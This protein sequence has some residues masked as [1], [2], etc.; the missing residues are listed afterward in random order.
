MAQLHRRVLGLSD[1]GQL[2][3]PGRS[4]QGAAH[5]ARRVALLASVLLALGVTARGAAQ[6]APVDVDGAAE[7][8][9]LA[10]PP[11]SA[12]VQM[13][14]EL[15]RERTRP[16]GDLG[17]DLGSRDSAIRVRAYDALRSLSASRV[18][19]V[20]AR[21]RELRLSND[22]PAAAAFNT[23]A[24]V[25][26]HMGFERA[27][28]PTDVALGVRQLLGAQRMPSSTLLQ[29]AER[30]ALVR[31]L[32][33]MDS[34]AADRVMIG[35]FQRGWSVWQWEARHVV[36]RRG[37]RMLPA[38]IEGRS[39]G[40]PEVRRWAVGSIRRLGV[41]SVGAAVQMVPP[42][43]L[44]DVLRAYASLSDLNAMPAVITFV[45]HPDD[46]VREASRAATAS[47]ERNAIWQ[48]RLAY[49][50]KLGENAD[51]SWSWQTT[52]QRLYDGLDARRL[53]PANELLDQGLVAAQAGDW[54][55]MRER[56]D[57]AL[58]REPLLPRRSEMG[59]GY[60]AEATQRLEQLTEGA[61]AAGVD[62]ALTLLRRAIRLSPEHADANAWRATVAFHEAERARE[63]G[64]LDEGAYEAVLAVR[65]DHAG[66]SAVLADIEDG[67]VGE[68]EPAGTLLAAKLLALLGVLL[69]LPYARLRPWAMRA[70]DGVNAAVARVR[71][72]RAREAFLVGATEHVRVPEVVAD[73]PAS[74][75][76]VVGPVFAEPATA[77]AVASS[78][79]E[80]PAPVGVPAYLVEPAH[81]DAAVPM[82][83][84]AYPVEPAHLDA[85]PLV[86]VAAPVVEP[87]RVA[88]RVET[89]APMGLLAAAPVGVPASLSDA[90]APVGALP[91]AAPMGVL[92]LATRP[93]WLTRVGEGLEPLYRT[94]RQLAFFARSLARRLLPA[95]AKAA[96]P[97]P[98]APS[99]ARVHAERL[100]ARASE[101]AP[102]LAQVVAHARH[103][104]EMVAALKPKK[105]LPSMAEMRKT[106]AMLASAEPPQVAQP[107]V[108][109]PAIVDPYVLLTTS[110]VACADEVDPESD[111]S[112][113]D[114][115][116]FGDSEPG[117]DT[118][119]DE[120]SEAP[121]QLPVSHDLLT[122]L[123]Q[124]AHDTSPG[125]I[126]APDT[127]PG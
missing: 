61:D 79:A 66:A 43:Q 124:F 126:E 73:A 77:V 22:P 14:P 36:A 102:A 47:Y 71:E 76:H 103:P 98:V 19:D 104:R 53:A 31:G 40:N 121:T 69:L 4:Q 100:L 90:P 118:A 10:P 41:D 5:L 119:D 17:A 94:A 115:L 84:P 87:A 2:A 82:G 29:V 18:T 44:P 57:R 51:L 96:A 1:R 81:L 60:A 26:H 75:P 111:E 64:V 68:V 11:P 70:R 92:P 28:D 34:L 117:L 62:G 32:E 35:F 45:D 58:R 39:A 12:P 67:G 108:V 21:L 93:T 54:E 114:E 16:L 72:R 97:A 78:L 52:M 24:D 30:M 85:T 46:A 101:R 125:L 8:L 20:E 13:T 120:L 3:H 59:P 55:T 9:P 109:A 127:L 25:R 99:K 56:Y 112:I 80:A 86:G 48:L 113:L 42:A 37:L 122:A 95:R 63:Q 50:N 65:P 88:A 49:R 15:A 116:L 74:V 33:H 83:V 106:L 38:L 110:P 91:L 89:P 105:K 123:A 6:E 7:P 107:P 23:L 27:D